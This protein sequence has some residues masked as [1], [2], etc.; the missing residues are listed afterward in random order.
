[1]CC[2]QPRAAVPDLLQPY[3]LCS[4]KSCDGQKEERD[5]DLGGKGVEKVVGRGGYLDLW[6]RA[7]DI[8]VRPFAATKNPLGREWHRDSPSG[9]VGSTDRLPHLRGGRENVG[10]E[11][12]PGE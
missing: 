7:K 10:I 9:A 1:M 2:R 3:S 8:W 11:S 12:T 5:C 6:G 4:T